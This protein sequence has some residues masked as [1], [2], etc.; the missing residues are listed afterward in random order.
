MNKIGIEVKPRPWLEWVLW[1]VWLLVEIFVL[2]NALASAAEMQAT[3]QIIF[4]VVF[5]VLL[6]GGVVV[7][8]IRRPQSE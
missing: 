3:A 6:I 1:L 4:W 2:Q 5:A 8:I 7:W